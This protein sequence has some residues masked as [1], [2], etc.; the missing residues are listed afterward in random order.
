VATFLVTR[1]AR[2]TIS[3]IIAAAA[4]GVAA[5]IGSMVIAYRSSAPALP[6]ST[7]SAAV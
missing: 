4:C 2:A 5:R 6:I 1:D 3:V 7:E